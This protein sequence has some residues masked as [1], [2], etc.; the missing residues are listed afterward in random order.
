MPYCVITDILNRPGNG[1]EIVFENRHAVRESFYGIDVVT[2]YETGSIFSLLVNSNYTISRMCRIKKQQYVTGKNEAYTRFTLLHDSTR[3][4][5]IYN[6][7]PENLTSA[8]DAEIKKVKDNKVDE[9]SIILTTTENNKITEQKIIVN[10]ADPKEIDAVLLDSSIDI[11]GKELF[12]L[13][14]INKEDYLMKFY[15]K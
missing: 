3:C 12:I 4:F 1:M 11:D 8:P 2:T 14:R 10:K 5:Y 13:R 7:L 15:L 6:E 9:T